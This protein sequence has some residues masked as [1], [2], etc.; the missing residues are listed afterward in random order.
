MLV[1]LHPG[2]RN[3]QNYNSSAASFSFRVKSPNSKEGKQASLHQDILAPRFTF[4]L[5]VGAE[6]PLFFWQDPTGYFLSLFERIHLY[7]ASFLG[8]LLLFSHSVYSYEQWFSVLLVCLSLLPCLLWHCASLNITQLKILKKK[9][10]KKLQF[11]IKLT[12]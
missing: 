3:A 9:M 5:Q 11:L 1:S 12:I 6:F 7:V 4:S 10:R 2:K 8:M